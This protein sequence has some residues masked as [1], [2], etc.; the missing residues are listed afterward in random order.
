ML[1]V[2]GAAV[3]APSPG[4]VIT[5]SISRYELI[6]FLV[7]VAFVLTAVSL[8]VV[9]ARRG[10]R[11]WSAW[12]PEVETAQTSRWDPSNAKES[13]PVDTLKSLA[14]TQPS[15]AGHV[16]PAR[17]AK[18]RPRSAVETDPTLLDIDRLQLDLER[19]K[20]RLPRRRVRPRD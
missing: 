13:V 19:I 10:Y 14:E 5:P 12:M 18:P 17:G 16:A 15:P 6:I 1:A 2:I 7:A 4:L 20:H 8:L 3:L 9:L 11:S